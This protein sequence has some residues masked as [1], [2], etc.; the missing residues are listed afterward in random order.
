M[1]PTTETLSANN[2]HR[3]FAAPTVATL[4]KPVRRL[5]FDVSRSPSTSMGSQLHPFQ[6][7][8][9]VSVDHLDQSL[10]QTQSGSDSTESDLTVTVHSSPSSS[11]EK[12]PPIHKPKE[13]RTNLQKCRSWGKTFLVGKKVKPEKAFGYRSYDPPAIKKACRNDH[14][15]TI[16]VRE[17]IGGLS[18]LVVAGIVGGVL[19]PVD[20]AAKRCF[21]LDYRPCFQITHAAVKGSVNLV[22]SLL[23]GGLTVLKE[24]V[25]NVG[26]VYKEFGFFGGT[27]AAVTLVP[28]TTIADALHAVEYSIQGTVDGA[29]DGLFTFGNA[30]ANGSSSK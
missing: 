5:S 29:R 24:T 16:G 11:P 21:N 12:N 14:K 23:L 13:K 20:S 9:S 2:R 19:Y 22:S 6:F 28:L 1:R 10:H 8:A 15:I 30:W 25:K 18:A 4:K 27:I 7:P 3:Q 26:K 17:S